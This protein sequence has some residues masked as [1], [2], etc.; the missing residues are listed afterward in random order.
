MP[1]LNFHTELFFSST[2]KAFSY[3]TSRFIFTNVK[4]KKHNKALYNET[5]YHKSNTIAATR[6]WTQTMPKKEGLRIP[7][8]KQKPRR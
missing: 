7:A 1:L 2:P 8:P 3:K 5:F 6:V 4:I